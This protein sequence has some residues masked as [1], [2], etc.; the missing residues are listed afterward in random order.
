MFK[1]HDNGESEFDKHRSP[2][3]VDIFPGSGSVGHFMAESETYTEREQR[4]LA[5]TAEWSVDYYNRQ[6]FNLQNN[7]GGSTFMAGREMEIPVPQHPVG[8]EI[9]S[10]ARNRRVSSRRSR[11]E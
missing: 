3:S 2:Q 11:N 4:E 7:E 8:L 5:Q 1:F 10:P 6:R 9:P